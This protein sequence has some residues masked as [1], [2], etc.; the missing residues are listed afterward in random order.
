MPKRL[1]SPRGAI[2]LQR[3][4]TRRNARRPPFHHDSGSPPLQRL[5]G[6][7]MAIVI[8]APQGNKQVA[9]RKGAGIDGDP[10]GLP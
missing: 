2:D 10:G 9:R 3:R 5:S 8:G 6:K 4:R 1:E 7:V